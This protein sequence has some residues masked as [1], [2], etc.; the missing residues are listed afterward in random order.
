[1]LHLWQSLLR[2][3]KVMTG[4]CSCFSF[5]SFGLRFA[6]I[7]LILFGCDDIELNPGPKH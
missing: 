4:S 2:K 1:M 7:L 3:S 5:I 6:F